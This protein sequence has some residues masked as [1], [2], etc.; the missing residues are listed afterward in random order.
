MLGGVKLE[1]D[2]LIA[3]LN[4]KREHYENALIELEKLRREADTEMKRVA[5]TVVEAEDRRKEILAQTYREAADIL[6]KT[7][8]KMHELMDEMKKLE[9]TKGLE[10]LREVKKKIEAEQKHVDEA[11]RKFEV[12]EIETPSA[13]ELREGDVVFVRSL[14][15]DAAIIKINKKLKRIRVG[16]GSLEIELPLSDIGLKRGRPV[17]E[18]KGDSTIG[19]PDEMPSSRINLVGLRVDEALSRLEPFL[20]HASMAGLSEVVVIH[21]LGSG[22]LSRAVREHLD[23]HPL[24]NSFRS[25]DRAEGGAGV[26][27]VTMA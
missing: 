10:A 20:N 26:T 21:G 25:G 11:L 5:Q 14:G 18:T 17:A 23:G 7:K 16:A 13:E 9:R 24:I 3:D 1:F 8:T 19:R 4:S 22:I 15:Y 2:N 27:V 6:R 12:E